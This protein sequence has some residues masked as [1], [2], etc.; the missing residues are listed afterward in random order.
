M[1][2]F[3]V[4]FLITI[5][6]LVFL[7][8]VLRKVL[9]E[10]VSRFMDD[11]SARIQRDLEGAKLAGERAK[12]IE[13][14]WSE[15]LKGS[16]EEGQR[17]LQ[18]AREKAEAEREAILAQARAEAERLIEATRA[19]IEME[20]REAARELLSD[21]ADLTIEA[22]AAVLGESVDT[23]RNR[24]IIEKFLASSGVA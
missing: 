23:E 7:Y 24:A 19:E 3:S 6:N 12:A 14:D 20:R 22:A 1:L 16:R 11:R 8:L 2:D 4:T 18:M 9:F 5:F 15:R 17:I 13:D 10:R 21:T